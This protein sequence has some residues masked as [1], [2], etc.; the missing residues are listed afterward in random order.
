MKNIKIAVLVVAVILSIKSG[1]MDRPEPTYTN[2]ERLANQIFAE[3]SDGISFRLEYNPATGVYSG[4]EI[5]RVQRTP[6]RIPA[7][8]GFRGLSADEAER[9]YKELGRVEKG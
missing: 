6:G 2:V 8:P 4:Q 9:L 3:R 5:R 7:S 1:A